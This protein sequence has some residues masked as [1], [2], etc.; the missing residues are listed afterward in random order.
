LLIAL[1]PSCRSVRQRI[2][3]AATVCFLGTLPMFFQFEM[4]PEDFPD[5]DKVVQCWGMVDSLMSS[6][7]ALSAALMIVAGRTRRLSLAFTGWLVCILGIFI[8]PVGILLMASCGLVLVTELLSQVF[9]PPSE[10]DR[11]GKKRLSPVMFGIVASVTGGVLFAITV[12]ICLHSPYMGKETRHL[13][14]D[15]LAVVKQL[16]PIAPGKQFLD[17]ARCVV[18]WPITI[19]LMAAGCWRYARWLSNPQ[20]ESRWSVLIRLSGMLLLLGASLSW[21]WFM[22]GPIPRY[23]FPFVAILLLW[24]VSDV[25]RRLLPLL[26][27]RRASPALAILALPPLILTTI[28]FLK[29]PSIPVQKLLGVNL[30]AGLR[31]EELQ[32]GHFLIRAA[33]TAGKAFQVYFLDG[34]MTE[35]PHMQDY[36]EW[37]HRKPRSMLLWPVRAN[38]WTGDPG[39]NIDRI[40]ECDY[41]VSERTH[42]GELD[43]SKKVVIDYSGEVHEFAA[44]LDGLG[45]EQGVVLRRFGRLNV[46]EF[47][48]RK[49]FEQS[50][51]RWASGIDWR[52]TFAERNKPKP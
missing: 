47:A 43:G 7:G 11:P 3:A 16:Y 14:A 13:Y 39:L 18:G 5:Y 21:W 24:S 8:K 17:F 30:S 46:V 12:W 42:G 9:G 19:I 52:T 40:L 38:Q 6:V 33:E 1:W 48:D 29:A 45:K 32:A 31:T 34:A 26:S 22:T 10:D 49:L 44:F 27:A 4:N 28:F 36:I 41:I 25:F 37:V 50:Y 20:E 23:Y 15:G 35:I 2:L 51:Q